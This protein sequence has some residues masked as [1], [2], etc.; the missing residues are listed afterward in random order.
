MTRDQIVELLDDNE[1]AFEVDSQ[2][3]GVLTIKIEIEEDTDE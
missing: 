1:V 3:D 2:V